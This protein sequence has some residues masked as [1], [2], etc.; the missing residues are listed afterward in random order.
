MIVP[1]RSTHSVSLPSRRRTSR[2]VLSR[3]IDG[4]PLFSSVYTRRCFPLRQY[5]QLSVVSLSNISLIIVYIDREIEVFFC[6]GYH[7]SNVRRD[8]NRV[9]SLKGGDIEARFVETFER[10]TYSNILGCKIQ[11]RQAS[12]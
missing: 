7:R 10:A 12:N 1:Y 11:F 9:T 2:I 8:S 6:S 5:A 4:V 3:F